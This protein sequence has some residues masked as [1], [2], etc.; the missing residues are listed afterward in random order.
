[1]AGYDLSDVPTIELDENEHNALLGEEADITQSD[2]M[3]EAVI[4]VDEDDN[5]VG[6]DSKIATHHNVGK[7]HRAFS[8]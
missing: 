7:L 5:V 1:M 2:L 6:S 3:S 4:C 8:V